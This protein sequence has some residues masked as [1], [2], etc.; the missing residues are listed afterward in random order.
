MRRV[1]QVVLS[2]VTG[3]VFASGLTLAASTPFTPHR[4][5]DVMTYNVYFG[6]DL[7]PI[8]FAATEAELLAAVGNAWA[9]VQATDIPLRADAIA[10][11]IAAS[12]PSVVG[13][14]EAARW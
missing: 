8:F 6:A 1:Y 4:V 3:I 10:D 12:A 9:N 5:A 14:Q 11:E 2:L 7:T 13:L